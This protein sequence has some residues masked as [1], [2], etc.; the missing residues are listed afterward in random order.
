MTTKQIA[1]DPIMSAYDRFDGWTQRTG[2]LDGSGLTWVVRI[3]LNIL[4]FVVPY[5]ILLVVGLV[6]VLCLAV[7]K[8]IRRPSKCQNQ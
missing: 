1:A 8:I 6:G 2:I 4:F 3:P 5:I 7:Q